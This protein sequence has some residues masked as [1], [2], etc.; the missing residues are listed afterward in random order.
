MKSEGKGRDGGGAEEGEMGIES[1]P[2]GDGSRPHLTRDKND[3][4]RVSMV[5]T[6]TICAILGAKICILA[7]SY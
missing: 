5:Y 2:D 4:K 3:G 6:S 7:G 1:N